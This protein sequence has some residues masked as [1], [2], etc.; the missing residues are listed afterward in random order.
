MILPDG[1]K[2]TAEVYQETAKNPECSTY[3]CLNVGEVGVELKLGW[4]PER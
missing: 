2:I 3:M 4:I 1:E